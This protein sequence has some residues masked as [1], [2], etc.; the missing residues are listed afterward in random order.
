MFISKNRQNQPKQEAKRCPTTKER[1]THFSG[2]LWM[3]GMWFNYQRV[4]MIT[5]PIADDPFGKA[6]RPSQA[7]EAHAVGTEIGPQSHPPE[8]SA[9]AVTMRVAVAVGAPGYRLVFFVHVM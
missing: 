9:M 7:L 2:D 6:E 4:C 1:R 8:S 3:L 5:W